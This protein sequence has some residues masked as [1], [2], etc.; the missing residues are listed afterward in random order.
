MAQQRIL[1]GMENGTI[2]VMEGEGFLDNLLG[3]KKKVTPLEI[4]QTKKR[5]RRNAIRIARSKDEKDEEDRGVEEDRKK[6]RLR[7]LQEIKD[8]RERLER[9]R[10]MFFRRGSSPADYVYTPTD[11]EVFTNLQHEK[12]HYEE[13]YD[14]Y[15]DKKSKSKT[16]NNKKCV[17]CFGYGIGASPK[18]PTG[19]MRTEMLEMIQ[20]H[21]EQRVDMRGRGIHHHSHGEGLSDV[22]EYYLS[23]NTAI[24]PNAGQMTS[25]DRVLE[26]H[27]M[28]FNAFASEE[29]KHRA[30]KKRTARLKREK[31]VGMMGKGG[32]Q[33][34]S[35]CP[36]DF[37]DLS[38]ETILDRMV[39]PSQTPPF[40]EIRPPDD[41]HFNQAMVILEESDE[42]MVRRLK[43]SRGRKYRERLSNEKQLLNKAPY[44]F[45]RYANAYN[46]YLHSRGRA[47]SQ[48]ETDYDFANFGRKSEMF[49][50]CERKSQIVQ[51]MIH[52]EK[53]RIQSTPALKNTNFDSNIK[54]QIQDFV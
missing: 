52:D 43:R 26:E 18:I 45:E 24:Q 13:D 50:V 16:P 27:P 47:L 22:I 54:Q 21:A 14:D 4:L 11:E 33:S 23:G 2:G 9:R 31:K 20:K 48:M 25:E 32:C 40:R 7:K 6:E 28:L 8:N 10:G 35:V 38:E 44:D 36:D 53:S 37:D 19:D 5:E 17:G 49:R 29:A 34:S 39:M 51:K 1:E 46:K 42:D 41:T 15:Y 3:R 12:E 30:T